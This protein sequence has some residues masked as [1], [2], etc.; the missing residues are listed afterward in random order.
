[1]D[2]L[3]KDIRYGMRSLLKRPAF[4]A[5]AVITLALGIGANTAIFSVVNAFLLRPLP[6]NEPDRLMMVD[7]QH[8]GSSIGVSFAD[9]QD[10]HTQNHVFEDMAFFNLRWNA[11]L[12]FGNETETLNLT[13]G[14]SNLFSTLGVAPFIGHGPQTDTPDTVM[15]S[16]GL[17][18]RRFGGDPG[19]L[20][21]QLRI[22]GRGLTVVGVMPA[23]FRFSFHT[24][25]CGLNE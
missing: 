16:Y 24:D 18:Q 3:L 15:I 8:L 1:M 21:K 13:F 7:S 11:N 12:E 25:L 6:Y 4:T 19:I 5:V 22:D 17:W 10:W 20:G 9:Y 2:A 23:D 14:T